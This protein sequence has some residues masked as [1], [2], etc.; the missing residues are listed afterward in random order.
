MKSKSCHLIKTMLAMD[1]KSSTL[2]GI[3][4]VVGQQKNSSYETEIDLFY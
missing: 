4:K 1:A 2:Q 3:G